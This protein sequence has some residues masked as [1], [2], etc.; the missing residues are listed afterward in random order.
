[1]EV[2]ETKVKSGI[3]E[4]YY[5]PTAEEFAIDKSITVIEND[6][7]LEEY[8]E[9]VKSFYK[10]IF[11]SIEDDYKYLID[12]LSPGSLVD[13]SL[14]SSVIFLDDYQAR[15]LKEEINDFSRELIN[16]FGEKRDGTN[17][18]SIGTYMLLKKN[19]DQYKKK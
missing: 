8:K 17:A 9:K 15:T 2:V 10:S 13:S 4:K 16:R 6:V 5:L 11:K 7:N 18:Y 12:N 1:M 19:Q 14:L 3:I